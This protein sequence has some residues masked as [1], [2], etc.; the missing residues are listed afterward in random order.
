MEIFLFVIS[1]ISMC[2]YVLLVVFTDVFWVTQL[3]WPVSAAVFT[4]TGL[5]LWV[6]RKRKQ[7]HRKCLPLEVRTA[8]SSTCGLYFLLV[9]MASAMILFRGFSADSGDVDYLIFIENGD[10]ETSL[11]EYDYN[12]LDCTIAYMKQHKD[13]S[14]VLAGCSRFRGMKADE[15][16]LQTLMTSYLTDHEISRERIIAEEISNNLKQNITYSYAYILVDWYGKDEEREMEPAVGIVAGRASVLRYELII[17]DLGG[18]ERHV[19]MIP[20][21][22][23]I[24]S[25]PARIMEEIRFILGYHLMN[26]FRY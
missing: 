23:A 18:M 3:Y 4:L 24:F 26:Q 10:V 21:E 13:T 19:N 6:D 25:W 22:E 2:Y 8:I 1:G 17:D 16:E 9:S 15:N 11:T 7:E 14:V 5:L 12:A 20:C